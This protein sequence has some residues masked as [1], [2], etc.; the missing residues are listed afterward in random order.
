MKNNHFSKLLTTFLSKYL[1]LQRN[2]SKN[3]ILSYCDTFRLLLTYYRDTLGVSAEHLQLK[4]FTD[5]SVSSF[6]LYLEKDRG[7]SISTRNQRL[8]A[9]HAFAKYCQYEMPQYLEHFQKI[10][11]LHFKKTDKPVVAYLSP[12]ITKLLLEQ[13][14]TSTKSG[15]RDLTLLSLMYDTGARVQ[16]VADLRVRDVH[17]CDS[18][19]VML[20]GKG[21]KSRN[22]PL[23]ENTADLL[24]SYL[25]DNR[26]KT[27]DKFD[28]PLFTNHKRDKLSRSGI[29]F[30][31]KKYADA[32]R[33]ISGDIPDKVTPHMLRH[34]KAMHLAEAN[35]NPIYIRDI[36]GHADVSTVSI[37]VNASMKMKRDALAKTQII[38]KEALPA[39][40]TDSSM[41]EWLKNYG[42]NIM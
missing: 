28:Y 39:W 7:C 8:A 14:D 34:T 31:V 6:L 40:A 18:S 11:R 26:L 1:P 33:E 3:T 21:R 2:L 27:P 15:R 5:S 30:I 35:V 32:V 9:I 29:A 17:L 13:P 41:I 20:T 38:Q 16:E 25:L 22:L 4:Q 42:K 37:Y 23:L 10:I 12:E 19:Y 36:L 24:E